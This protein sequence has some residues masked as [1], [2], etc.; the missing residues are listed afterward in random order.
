M[1]KTL[2]QMLLFIFPRAFRFRCLKFLYGFEIHPSAR[3]GF[4]ILGAKSVIINKNAKVGHLN[5]IRN[6]DVLFLDSGARIGSMNWIAGLSISQ[7][8]EHYLDNSQRRSNLTI[9]E[10]ASITNQHLLDCT[11]HITIKRF[12]TVAGYRSQILTHEIDIYKS[13]QKSSP[14]I[15]GE[16]SFIGSGVIIL[17]GTKFPSSSVLMAGSLCRISSLDSFSLFGGVP[18]KKIKKYEDSAKYFFRLNGHVS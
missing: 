4:S 11:D 8:K 10:N 17:A 2:L 5:L 18:A 15:I 6:V 9:E 1:G 14:V 7:S 3:I 16:Y 12:S 13:T